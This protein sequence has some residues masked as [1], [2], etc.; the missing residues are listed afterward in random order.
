MLLSKFYALLFCL[1]SY[2]ILTLYLTVFQ[3]VQL[4]R[5]LIYF[6]FYGFSDLL[7]LTKTLLAIL[8]CVPDQLNVDKLGSEVIKINT[9]G[10]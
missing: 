5:N 8:D 4:C 3:V 10:K 1:L 6:G 7:R 9:A 2:F